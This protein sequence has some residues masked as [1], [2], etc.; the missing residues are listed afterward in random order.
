MQKACDTQNF[1]YHLRK[2][3]LKWYSEAYIRHK[4]T[5]RKF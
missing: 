5:M 2:N 1:D 3:D 4:S